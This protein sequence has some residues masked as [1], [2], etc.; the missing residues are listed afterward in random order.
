MFAA[1]LAVS[2][3]TAPYLYTH[4][5]TLMLIPVLLVLGSRQWSVASAERTV[6][7]AVI[8]LLY[9]P[10]VYIAILRWHVMYL[11][12]PVL[13]IFAFA[14]ISMARKQA[15]ELVAAG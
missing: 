3:V 11:L 9:I 4:D 10:L 14:A 5:M 1:A 7:L 15:F 2:Q 6:L 8:L 12:A 13:V